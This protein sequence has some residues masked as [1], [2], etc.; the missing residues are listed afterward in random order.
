MSGLGL[1]QKQTWCLFRAAAA[2]AAALGV[3][4]EVYRHDVM[5]EEA[6]VD[7]IKLLDRRAGYEAVMTRMWTDAGDYEMA[8]R[9]LGGDARRLGLLCEACA[10]QIAQITGRHE[11]GG[12][13]YVEGVLSQAGYPCRPSSGAGWCLDLPESSTRRVF[14]MLD[15]HRRRLLRQAGARFAY[16]FHLD[17]AYGFDDAGH[18]VMTRQ[19]PSPA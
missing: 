10:N 3:D 11:G 16:T 1:T 2:G 18:L 4:R 6:G 15:T 17:A 14:A 9:F 13:A 19:T 12:R 5:R 8:A 7:S